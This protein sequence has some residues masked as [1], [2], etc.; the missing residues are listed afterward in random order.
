[1]GNELNTL[2]SCLEAGRSP[3]PLLS[4]FALFAGLCKQPRHEVLFK[5]QDLTATTF[6]HAWKGR[7]KYSVSG[8]VNIQPQRSHL[9]LVLTV[10]FC[11]ILQVSFALLKDA[12]NPLR[13]EQS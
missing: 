1:M 8:L 5:P 13:A 4:Q 7:E 11:P 12:S 2:P 10:C 9:P 6:E 3:H